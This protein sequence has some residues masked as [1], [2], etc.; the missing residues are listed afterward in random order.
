MLPCSHLAWCCNQQYLHILHTRKQYIPNT[1]IVHTYQQHTYI[2]LHIHANACS[3]PTVL[4]AGRARL[5]RRNDSFEPPPP[6]LVRSRKLIPRSAATEAHRS[7]RG[8]A[9]IWRDLDSP[10]ST[11]ESA[12]RLI[13]RQIIFRVFIEISC[14]LQAGSRD[15]QCVGRPMSALLT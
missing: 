8:I 12:Q 11:H 14:R 1:H 6:A 10:I 9:A 7:L 2:Y 15:A 4:F 3:I 13:R 5:R